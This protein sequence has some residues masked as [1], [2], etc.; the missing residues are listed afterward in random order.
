[1]SLCVTVID[2][3]FQQST[4]GTCEYILLSQSQVTQLVNGQFDW[5]LFEFDRDLYDFILKQTLVTFIG[6]HILG[7]VLKYFGKR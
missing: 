4:N 5:S 3:I 1:M 7:R 6:G 2:G